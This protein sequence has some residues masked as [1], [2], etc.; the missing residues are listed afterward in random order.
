MSGNTCTHEFE[1]PEFDLHGDDR[2]DGRRWLLTE[3]VPGV[4][5]RVWHCAHEPIDGQETCL[6]HT[7]PADRPADRDETS[8][9][10]DA[11]EVAT[12]ATT[13]LESRRLL[14]FIDAEFTELSLRGV[15]VGTRQNH[16]I[17]L[18]A[19]TI[20]GSDWT[21]AR[22][23]QPVR[24]SHAT[25]RD[26]LTARDAVFERAAGF[27]NATFDCKT[28]FRGAVFSAP[29]FLKHASFLEDASFWY[30]K[31]ERHVNF[32]QATFEKDARFEAADFADYA[33]FS[34]VELCGE[35]V[36]RLVEF[37]DDA[38][39]DGATFRGTHDFHGAIFNRMTDFSS[40]AVAGPLDLSAAAF[41]DLRLDPR[42]DEATDRYIDLRDCT[43]ES[44][45][46]GQPADGRVLYDLTDAVVGD[47]QFTASRQTP[48]A[49]RVRF[50]RTRFDGFVFEDDDLEPAATSWDLC[51]VFDER[52]LPPES[53]D[54]PSTEARRQTFLN[55]KNGAEQTGNQ[56]AASAF[57]YR[58]L[59][60]R[61]R[62]HAELAQRSDLSLEDRLGNA[63]RWFR[64]GTMMLL[65]GYG[66]RPDRV[67]YVSLLTVSLFAGIYAVLLAGS[68]ETLVDH[69]MFSF[70]SFVAFVPG[71][72]IEGPTRAVELVSSF[73]AFVGAFFIALFVF[74]FTRRIK[75]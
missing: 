75:R 7:N 2:S 38:D 65:T 72:G 57:F 61:R 67:V 30:T 26:E 55:A 33:R 20:G 8:A 60:Y 22:F 74:T 43:I 34:D 39:F 50:L 11:L 16:A 45:V 27:R 14:Q 6:F 23:I 1:I 44:G 21:D 17:N 35:T 40:V 3:D 59:S 51:A 69:L 49:N 5:D 46:L 70:Q 10:L 18:A 71:S 37:D 36:F 42:S 13:P 54:E 31:F 9:F 4:V 56:T 15:T 19:A 24:F 28:S 58:E 73:Q 68:D 32:W 64:N 12:E 41:V 47:V 25:F 52:L 62:R 63:I 48:I 29:A 66:E 53:R